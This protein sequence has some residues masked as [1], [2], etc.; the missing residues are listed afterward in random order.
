M[1]SRRLSL[2]KDRQVGFN[3]R[4]NLQSVPLIIRIIPSYV[5]DSGQDGWLSKVAC[6]SFDKLSHCIRQC[7][8]VD[9][10][11]PIYILFVVYIFFRE[12]PQG[13]LSADYFH[14]SDVIT[15]NVET[16]HTLPSD[17]FNIN[18][19]IFIG[20]KLETLIK[21]FLPG[22]NKSC[23][24]MVKTTT[25]AVG[26]WTDRILEIFCVRVSSLSETL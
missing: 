11:V 4:S 6:F 22:S 3:S 24:T 7:R 2:A 10:S 16:P 26:C 13:L 14:L 21:A 19:Y 25:V 5:Q 15:P 17:V 18:G 9:A 1:Y 20:I 23:L 8:C 12:S